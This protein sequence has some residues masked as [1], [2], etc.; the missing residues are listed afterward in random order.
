MNHAT[1]QFLRH[2]SF[3]GGWMSPPA[4]AGPGAGFNQTLEVFSKGIDELEWVFTSI[5]PP[6]QTRDRKYSASGGRPLSA[7]SASRGLGPQWAQGGFG[8]EARKSVI[9]GNG[10][11]GFLAVIDRF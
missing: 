6:S 5:Q 1:I 7:Y 8:G 11:G 4:H 9:V 2:G 10:F 3:A